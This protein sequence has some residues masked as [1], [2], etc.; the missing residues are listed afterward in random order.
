MK[1]LR[2]FLLVLLVFLVAI[3]FINPEKN[4]D[5]YRSVA[6]FEQEIVPTIEISS[7]LKNNCYDCH[8]DQTNYP[9]Y[10]HISPI[11]YW[12]QEHIEEGKRHFNASVW[13]KYSAR[14]KDHKLEELIEY[15]EQGE[16]PLNS[17][18]WLHGDLSTQDTKTLLQ[19]AQISRIKYKKQMLELAK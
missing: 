10:N 14:K 16:M 3:Q 15:V 7:I 8:S 5:G 6:L 13:F 19:W 2:Y 11:N 9:W 18:T 4:N 1:Y 17:Y 12:L